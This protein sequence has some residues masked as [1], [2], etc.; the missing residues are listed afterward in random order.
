MQRGKDL[1]LFIF[2][3][4]LLFLNY[5]I[6]KLAEEILPYYLYVVWAVLILIIGLVSTIRE[7]REKK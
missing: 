5:P 2:F 4:G 6:M 7:Y 1:W 3:L